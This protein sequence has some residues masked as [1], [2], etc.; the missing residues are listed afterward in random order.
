MRLSLRTLLG[1][2][3]DFPHPH[4]VHYFRVALWILEGYRGFGETLIQKQVAALH[5]RLAVLANH[6]I[7]KIA[8][9]DEEQLQL[10]PGRIHSF[11]VDRAVFLQLVQTNTTLDNV[12]QLL[13]LELIPHHDDVLQG[14]AFQYDLLAQS[15]HL[16]LYVGEQHVFAE[17]G[18]LAEKL[19]QALQLTLDLLVFSLIPAVEV[20]LELLLPQGNQKCVFEKE[21][22]VELA[23]R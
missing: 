8:F 6:V 13:L 14:L 16:P 15:I 11:L 22:L 20:S 21:D 2:H 5:Q 10:A 19:L 9:P 7:L 3:P 4:E 23:V 12:F 17:F 1:Y 18:Y